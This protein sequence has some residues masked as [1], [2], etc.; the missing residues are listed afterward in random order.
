MHPL[1]NPRYNK[2]DYILRGVQQQCEG[3]FLMLMDEGASLQDLVGLS[4]QIQAAVA[5]GLQQASAKATMALGPGPQAS[6][7][8]PEYHPPP[9]DDNP[10][11]AP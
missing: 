8:P 3:H 9:E 11:V 10:F 4:Q 7:H 5:E 1:T 6:P 2:F